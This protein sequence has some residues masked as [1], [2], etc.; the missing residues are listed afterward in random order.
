MQKSFKQRL[1]ALE[2]LEVIEAEQEE[3]LPA[4]ATM[5]DD[6]VLDEVIYALQSGLLYS[7]YDRAARRF[8][9]CGVGLKDVELEFWYRVLCPRAQP[10]I[11]AHADA[12]RRL[13]PP[14]NGD[15][16]VTSAAVRTVLEELLMP[17]LSTQDDHA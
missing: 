12:I 17:S 11:D 2:A 1:A 7:W 10:L 9:L 3:R 6:E 8:W 4:V 13:V 5:A 16:R 15:R 14:N